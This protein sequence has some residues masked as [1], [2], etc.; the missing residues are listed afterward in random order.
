MDLPGN[1]K[2]G[3]EFKAID[4]SRGPKVNDEGQASDV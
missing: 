2:E 4:Y 1:S 3:T